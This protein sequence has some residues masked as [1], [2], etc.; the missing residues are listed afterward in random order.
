M[1]H[2]HS[3][4]DPVRN[5]QGFKALRSMWLPKASEISENVFWKKKKQ[6][7]PKKTPQKT[8]KPIDTKKEYQTT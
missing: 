1:A 8:P 7:Q 6:N 4:L 2:S 5:I 3:M